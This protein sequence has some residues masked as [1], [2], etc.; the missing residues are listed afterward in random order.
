MGAMMMIRRIITQIARKH[1]FDGGAGYVVRNV[2][3]VK[4]TKDEDAGEEG[5]RC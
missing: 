5:G 1:I 2:F 3:F 4:G